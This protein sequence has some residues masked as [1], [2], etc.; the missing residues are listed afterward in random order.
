MGNHEQTM[1]VAAAILARGRYSWIWVVPCCPYCGR[2]HAHYGGG[3]ECD[4]RWYLKHPLPAS[5]TP[6][7]SCGQVPGAPSRRRYILQP[8]PRSVPERR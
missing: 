8:D 4:P 5:C 6:G 3:L 1:L 2:Q 7:D